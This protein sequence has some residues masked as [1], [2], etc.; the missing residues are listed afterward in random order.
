VP[1]VGMTEYES[2]AYLGAL[3]LLGVGVEHLVE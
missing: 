3:A 2:S 1:I